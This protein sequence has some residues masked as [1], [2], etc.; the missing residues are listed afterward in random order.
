[1]RSLFIFLFICIIMCPLCARDR[2]LVDGVHGS[3][4]MAYPYMN[5]INN[6][7]DIFPDDVVTVVTPAD[8]PGITNLVDTLATDFGMLNFNIDLPDSITAG[9]V[10]TLYV[11][12]ECEE[13]FSFISGTIT[14]PDGMLVENL[15]A[16]NGHIDGA[17]GA[18]WTIH[19]SFALETMYQPKHIRIGYGNT[20]FSSSTHIGLYNP[21]DYDA[22]LSFYINYYFAFLEDSPDYSNTDLDALTEA[23]N[24]GLNMMLAYDFETAIPAKPYIHM[25]TQKPIAASI[26]LTIPGRRTLAIPKPDDD[27]TTLGWSNIQLKPDSKN[28][29]LWESASGTRM[30]FIDFN[31]AGSQLLFKNQTD[32]PLYDLMLIKNIDPYHFQIGSMQ[33]LTPNTNDQINKWDIYSTD[34][35]KDFLKKCLYDQCL[36]VKLTEQEAFHFAN[37]IPWVDILILRALK[38]PDQFFGFYHFDNDIYD[39]FIPLSVSP[40]PSSCERNMWVM[41]SNIQPR[42]SEPVAPLSPLI[43]D[44]NR[45]NDDEFVYREYGMV[46]ERYS[47]ANSQRDMSFFGFDIDENGS[48]ITD[49][50]SYSNPFACELDQYA[51]TVG[52]MYSTLKFNVENPDQYGVFHFIGDE[53][54]PIVFAKPFLDNGKL[55][56]IGNYTSFMFADTGTFFAS[57]MNSLIHS[58]NLVTGIEHPVTP[59]DNKITMRNYPNPFN[60]ETT[61]EYT[62]PSRGLVIIDLY[63]IKG[64]LIKHLLRNVTE[65]GI[66]TV[67]WNGLNDKGSTVGSQVI[68]CKMKFNGQEYRR[69]IVLMK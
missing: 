40:I 30:N 60:P 44:K 23:F 15:F 68:F 13:H 24:N 35:A 21:A 59:I 25:Y 39:R 54:H 53:L 8:I 69:K 45:S 58:P 36:K 11:S 37:E 61:I 64:Q 28:E 34:Q 31:V 17:Y 47:R 56:V 1:M 63:N 6:F 27:G 19:L 57:A 10:Q 65:P 29:H 14:N 20:L 4:I 42:R 18:G 50:Q 5:I 32:S 3:L 2:I 55:M 49:I 52:T 9:I 67:K 41:L 12:V 26:Q 62:I 16:G 33:V 46:D 43:K 66:H 7:Q 48:S 22:F 38:H 51:S